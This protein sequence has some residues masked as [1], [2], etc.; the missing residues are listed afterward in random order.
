MK[1][2]RI[3]CPIVNYGHIHLIPSRKKQSSLPLMSEYSMHWN[4]QLR[5]TRQ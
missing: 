5:P 1:Q 2:P 4:R 3:N